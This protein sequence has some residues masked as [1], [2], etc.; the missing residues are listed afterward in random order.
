MRIY[1]GKYSGSLRSRSSSDTDH[2]TIIAKANALRNPLNALSKETKT[3]IVKTL[4]PA[5]QRLQETHATLD[6][7]ID[8]AFGKGLLDF[9]ELCQKFERATRRGRAELVPVLEALPVCSR[10]PLRQLLLTSAGRPRGLGRSAQ[11]RLRSTCPI[12]HRFRSCYRR[13]R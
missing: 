8:P 1:T 10:D 11:R 12:A 3:E 7:R 13:Y 9:D 4:V 6:S 5:V 2:Q